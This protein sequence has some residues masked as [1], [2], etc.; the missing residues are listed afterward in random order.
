MRLLKPP[1]FLSL[2]FIFTVIY[3]VQGEA[4][5]KE[6]VVGPGS[7][8][9]VRIGSCEKQGVEC[10]EGNGWSEDTVL[11]NEDYIYTHSLP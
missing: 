7:S 3:V 1:L 4:V 2:V 6:G 5:T 8:A 11:E 10:T 9:T